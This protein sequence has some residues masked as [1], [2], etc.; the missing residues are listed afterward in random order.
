MLYKLKQSKLRNTRMTEIQGPVVRNS[1]NPLDGDFF[2]CCKNVQKAIRLQIWSWQ[3][4]QQKSNF[5]M[6]KFNLNQIDERVAFGGLK[7]SLSDG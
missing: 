4:M 1:D 3:L 5:K 6:Q 7:T 2:N